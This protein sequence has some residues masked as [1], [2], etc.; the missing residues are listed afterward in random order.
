M[1]L[2]NSFS[3]L[4]DPMAQAGS[5]SSASHAAAGTVVRRRSS[6]I[7]VA[8]LH[9]VVAAQG[10]DAL[11]QLAVAH[12]GGPGRFGEVL[13]ARQ[14]RLRIGF[15]HEH[16]AVAAHAKIDAG[17]TRHAQVAVVAARPAVEL[18]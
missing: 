7:E 3:C 16:A 18:L 9:A 8:P 11:E 12:T 14:V 10:H 1:N 6:G 5:S 2:S 15:Q 13:F 4:L 17:A